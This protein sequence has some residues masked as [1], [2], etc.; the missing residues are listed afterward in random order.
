MK[1]NLKPLCLIFLILFLMNCP[2]SSTSTPTPTPWPEQFH[3]LLYM[4]I[5]GKPLHVADLWYDW[6]K[7][8]SF[9][10][11]RRQLVDDLLYNAEWGNGTSYYFT[12]G[13][14]PTCR[15]VDYGVG[16]P[17]PDFLV[18][19]NYLGTRVSDGFLCHVWE[20]VGFI[21]YYEDVLTRRPVHWDFSDDSVV[22]APAPCFNQDRLQSKTTSFN[23]FGCP[24]FDLNLIK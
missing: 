4:N 17:R 2:T 10:I 20:K 11:H 13:P 18:D 7:R 16:I 9:Y 8:R 15:V 22:Q 1:M 19:A 5:S 14:N 24:D 12:L 3:A 23:K 21:W 6:P